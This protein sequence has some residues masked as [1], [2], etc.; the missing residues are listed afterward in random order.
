MSSASELRQEFRDHGVVIVRHA[1]DHAALRMAEEAY[2]WSLAHPGFGASKFASR[3]QAATFYQ[4]LANP[5][6]VA[7]YLPMLRSSPAA[8]IAAGLWGKPEV[9]FMYEQ[10]FLKE[11]GESRRTPWHQDASYLPIEGEHLAVAWITF[12][13]VAKEN[14]LEF[15]RGSHRGMLYDGSR[16]DLND[17]TA[18]IYGTLPRLPE[19]ERERARFD[20]VSWAVDP[21]DVL[22]FHFRTLHGGAPTHPGQRRRTLSLRFFGGDAVYAPRIAGVETAAARVARAQRADDQRPT[23]AKLPDV[24]APAEPF[25]HPDFPK[26]RPQSGG[27][28]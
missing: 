9:W 22:F 18:P 27:T 26:L 8:D 28:T 23:L 25:R 11:G 1:L 12:E 24:L 3:D 20:I 6:A 13:P 17:D 14:A 10:V 19:I 16:F 21:G 4:D 2:N 5:K 7:E 15:V